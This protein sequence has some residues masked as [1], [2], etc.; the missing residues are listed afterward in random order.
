MCRGPGSLITWLTDSLICAPISCNMYSLRYLSITSRK[1]FKSFFSSRIWNSHPCAR[2]T[3]SLAFYS[4]NQ[5]G[6]FTF[7]YPLCY[8]LTPY[9]Y[10]RDLQFSGQVIPDKMSLMI[11][12]KC[13]KY[14]EL[15]ANEGSKKTKDIPWKS[16]KHIL[17]PR[18]FD[19]KKSSTKL[20]LSWTRTVIS[21]KKKIK[22][23]SIVNKKM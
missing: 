21:F 20:L 2:K 18:N 6:S 15:P 9:L 13:I 22:R 14:H 16:G 23:K 3:Y 19:R 10:F 1:G 4:K 8:L 7:L 17:Q 11:E 12:W 5:G